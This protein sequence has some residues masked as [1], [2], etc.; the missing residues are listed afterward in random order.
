MD[1]VANSVDG[2]AENYLEWLGFVESKLFILLNLIAKMNEIA[3]IRA[4]PYGFKNKDHQELGLMDKDICKYQ[5]VDTYFL[6]FK[7]INNTQNQ[8]I[9]LEEPVVQFCQKI[10][11][12]R[13]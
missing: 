6:G 10:D 1:I 11:F 5:F 9:N 8:V 3:E 12:G 4:F 2:N 7:L 13:I